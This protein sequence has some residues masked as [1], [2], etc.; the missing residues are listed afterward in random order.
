[1]TTFAPASL[2]CVR[3][4]LCQRWRRYLLDGHAVEVATPIL[5]PR[6]DIAP[7]RQFTTTHPGT[8]TPAYLR[9][10][11]TEYLKRLLAAGQ[12]RIFEFSANFRDDAPDPTHLPEFTS[13]EVM[14][15]DA[16][17]ADMERT[18]ADLCALA[19]D[20]ARRA[21]PLAALPL[22]V[23]RWDEHRIARIEL[24][25]EL[26]QRFGVTAAQLGQPAI[27]A[28]LL[29][30]LG[31]A[32]DPAARVPGL[33]DQLVTAIARRHD[34][35][36]LICGFPEPLGGPAAPHPT[37]TGFK[38]R[39]EL[40]AGGLELANMSGNLTDARALRQWH[41]DGVQLKADLGIGTNHLDTDLLTALD[42]ALPPSAV[43]GIGVERILQATL[44]LPDIR[45]LRH[46]TGMEEW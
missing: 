21:I 33:L 35:A 15:R 29:G 17:C 7:V 26:Y 31:E 37:R 39:S 20:V 1:M 36:V 3:S 38:Q 22:W 5:H 6:P 16:T 18:A 46:P 23:Q 12:E 9:I 40:F 8:G 30:D 41:V 42:G 25:D 45:V 2:T 24:A 10:A 27:L 34:G 14:A 11:P 44:N 19:V 4:D 32:A 43:L 28:R 13:L